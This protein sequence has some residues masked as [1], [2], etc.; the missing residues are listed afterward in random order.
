MAIVNSSADD[1]SWA[2]AAGEGANSAAYA[3]SS[4]ALAN[5]CS[6]TGA[7]AMAVLE[8]VFSMTAAM[9]C[10]WGT[11]RIVVESAIFKVREVC[12]TECI[13]RSYLE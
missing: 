7:C 10:A 8:N 6:S 4:R 9:Y 2:N 3:S 13:Q 1:R 5:C 12:Q 11:L